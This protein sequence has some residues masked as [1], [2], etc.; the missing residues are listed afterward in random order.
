MCLLH[1]THVGSWGGEKTKDLFLPLLL[2]SPL[3]DPFNERIKK[4]IPIR[5]S[6]RVTEM[7]SKIYP[8]ENRTLY[9]F[10][11]EDMDEDGGGKSLVSKFAAY[12]YDDLRTL[13]EELDRRVFE[14]RHGTK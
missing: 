2:F 13:R 5:D 6:L 8:G 3:Q 7:K 1:F 12:S 10:G 11:I 14:A 9:T 4:C